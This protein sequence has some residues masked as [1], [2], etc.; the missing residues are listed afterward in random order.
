MSTDPATPYRVLVVAKAPIPGRVKTRLGATIGHRSSAQLA[1]AALL[2]TIIVSTRAVGAARCVIALEGELVDGSLAA[3]LQHELT[4]WRIVPQR[5]E[6]LGERIAAA[7]EDVGTGPVVQI[8]M[9]TPQVTV[10]D[11]DSL[12]DLLTRAS[13]SL[14]P[15]ADGGWWA[16]AARDH[17]LANAIHTVPMSLP[18]TY[19]NT[20]RALRRTGAL[21]QEAHLLVDVDTVDDA[22]HVAAN[23]P[24]LHFSRRWAGV[25]GHRSSP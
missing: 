15:A 22:R 12:G 24:D 11:L 17:L 23:H 8:G 13:A 9:D 16:L 3:Q 20:L 25:D 18:S 21:V 4:G 6:S 14:A 10:D 7:H 1:A 5:G 2:D 19:D